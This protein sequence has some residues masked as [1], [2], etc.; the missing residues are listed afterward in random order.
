MQS[1]SPRSIV[2]GG[3]LADI[4]LVALFFYGIFALLRGSRRMRRSWVHRAADRPLRL[5]VRA[6][7]KMEAMSHIFRIRGSSCRSSHDRVP[8]DFAGVDNLGQFR[9]FRGFL[10]AASATRSTR[11]LGGQHMEQP[12]RR[13][14]DRLRA[15]Q[16]A[17]LLPVQ[18]H[19]SDAAISP[20]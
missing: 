7:V 13:R 19:G 12:Q 5:P 2:F 3:D 15:A 17:G 8:H 10:S 4:A 16:P 11:L 9:L 14:A 18:R 6:H 20:S 1:S